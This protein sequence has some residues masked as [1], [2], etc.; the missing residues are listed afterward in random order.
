MNS[1]TQAAK[2][3]CATFGHLLILEIF[4][5]FNCML[6]IAHNS[7]KILLQCK[8]LSRQTQFK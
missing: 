7:S 1:G 5:N 8:D 2:E 6:L 3:A 4:I